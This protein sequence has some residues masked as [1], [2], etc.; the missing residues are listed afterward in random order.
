MKIGDLVKL[1]KLTTRDFNAVFLV[2]DTM[3]L[4]HTSGGPAATYGDEN[5]NWLKLTGPEC[6]S[7]SGWT[8]SIDYEVVSESRR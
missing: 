3:I 4:F 2:V 5:A 6:L 7:T 8:R 1:K